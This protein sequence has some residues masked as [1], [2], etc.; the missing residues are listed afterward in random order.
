[1]K[2]ILKISSGILFYACIILSMHSCDS[3]VKGC[4]DP[5]S[6]NFDELAEKN[7][8]S[9]EY[10][11]DAVIWYNKATSEGLIKDGATALTF[12]IDGEVV[13]SSAASV[14]WTGEPDCGDNGTISVTE[15]LGH[16]KVKSFIL[17]VKDQ[18]DFE[19]WNVEVDFEAN[20]CMAI[21]L[22]WSMRRKK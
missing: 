5:D 21:E 22:T 18:D 16:D 15:Y 2:T 19:Y 1:M 10:E 7:D 6:I 11:S 3:K 17:S 8:G 13:G 9:C 4:T 12:Y 20:T 14:Y